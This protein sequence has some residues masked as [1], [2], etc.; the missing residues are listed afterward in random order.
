MQKQVLIPVGST[1]LTDLRGLG[2]TCGIGARSPF[3]KFISLGAILNF[4]DSLRTP[5]NPPVGN[6]EVLSSFES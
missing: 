2:M 6:C 5:E 3:P 1:H 4:G